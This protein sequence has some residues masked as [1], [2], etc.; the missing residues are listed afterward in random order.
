MIEASVYTARRERLSAYLAK[1]G[2]AAARFEDFE[3]MRS[4]NVRYFS[5]HPGDAFLIVTAD[6]RSIL[7]PWD[8]NMA[9]KCA[10][11]D[12]IIPYTSFGRKAASA[13]LA[14]AGKLE[15]PHGSRIALP[16]STSYIRYIDF[17]EVLEDHDMVCEEGGVD[18]FVIGMRSVKDAGELAVYREA[19]RI[20]D[21]LMDGIEAR[22]RAGELATEVDVALFIERESRMLGCEGTGFETLAAGP[23]RSFGIHAVPAYGAGP[24]ATEG[25]S[26]LDCGVVLEGYT[27]DITMTF[28]QGDPGTERE[29]MIG[30]VREA[31]D[32]AVA[33]CAP[34]V[35]TRDIAASCRRVISI[36]PSNAELSSPTRPLDKFTK[37]I[38]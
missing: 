13:T 38:F 21:L 30:L 10:H 8:I 3:G 26:I 29:R 34:G 27:T 4:R 23:G 6:G 15:L 7:V 17:V 14:V 35:A 11:V 18:D 5:G 2:L 32:Q 25:M 9:Q 19:S 16:S 24:F 12:D 37:N 22:V 1:R 20:T 31:Y 28:V 36:A 33:M